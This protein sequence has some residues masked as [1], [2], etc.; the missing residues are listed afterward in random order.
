MPDD[1][2]LTARALERLTDGIKNKGVE[3]VVTRR[4]V[5]RCPPSV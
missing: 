2:V 1:E 4:Y 3:V 5:E